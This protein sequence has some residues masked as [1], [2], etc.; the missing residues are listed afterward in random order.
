MKVMCRI[1]RY[2][3]NTH[4]IGL[5]FTKINEFEVERYFDVD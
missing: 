3:K 5:L 2:L 4:G 1:L